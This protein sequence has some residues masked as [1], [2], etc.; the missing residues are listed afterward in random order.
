MQEALNT[1]YTTASI[2]TASVL[3]T[4]YVAL[5]GAPPEDDRMID[6]PAGDGDCG[7]NHTLS[8]QRL[9]ARLVVAL[10]LSPALT[11]A[12]GCSLHVTPRPPDPMPHPAPVQEQAGDAGGQPSSA[13]LHWR[14]LHIMQLMEDEK[15]KLSNIYLHAL[16]TPRGRL[17]GDEGAVGARHRGRG[18]PSEGAVGEEQELEIELRRA[19]Q[20][21]EGSRRKLVL[22]KGGERA[23]EGSVGRRRIP[24]TSMDTSYFPRKQRGS[25]TILWLCARKQS[26]A[27]MNSD[28]SQHSGQR[29]VEPMMPENVGPDQFFDVLASVLNQGSGIRRYNNTKQPIWITD[30][31]FWTVWATSTR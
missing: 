2:N 23:N 3:S 5:C 11:A 12:D 14:R 16:Q 7:P 22:V 4:T 17:P 30:I 21:A 10:P 13:I 19:V 27:M 8:H 24:H 29:T 1:I 9:S 25:W 31:K 28:K 20:S 15:S 18:G 26:E 6:E